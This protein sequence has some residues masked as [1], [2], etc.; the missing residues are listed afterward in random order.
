MSRKVCVIQGQYLLGGCIYLG[1]V[2]Q[3]RQRLEVAVE[4]F[5]LDEKLMYQNPIGLLQRVHNIIFKQ[6]AGVK[7]KHGLKMKLDTLS[8]G[9]P[10]FGGSLGMRDT[11]DILPRCLRDLC[12]E[13]LL[14]RLACFVSKKVCI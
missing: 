5:H 10:V 2:E 9:G 6:L 12:F 4:L 14:P 11:E 1:T 3:A 7:T 13:D 8:E